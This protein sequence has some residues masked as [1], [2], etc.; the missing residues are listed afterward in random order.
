MTEEPLG[1]GAEALA[2]AT[3]TAREARDTEADV[4]EDWPEVAATIKHRVRSVLVPS[5]PVLVFA[6]DGRPEVD[7]AGDQVT[8]AS[9]DLVVGLRT[10]LQQPSY[11][12]ADVDLEIRDRR[13][14]GVRVDV[15]ARY[16]PLQP[17][18]PVL[19]E[20]WA[21]VR[22]LLAQRVGPDPDLDASRDV[23]VRVV[24]IVDGDPSLT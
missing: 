8:V 22:D 11:A 4:P 24:D 16:A 19:E 9:R 14:V 5:R 6:A 3:A 13:L 7:G 10:R 21:A 12:L 2:L 17:L 23:S 15:V 20:V 1:A 18:R